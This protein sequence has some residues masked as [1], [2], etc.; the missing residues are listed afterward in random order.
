MYHSMMM[1]MKQESILSVCIYE[2][3]LCWT[4]K[5]ILTAP[6]ALRHCLKTESTQVHLTHCV[7]AG[8]C[9][10]CALSLTLSGYVA[11]VLREMHMESTKH[12][13]CVQSVRVQCGYFKSSYSE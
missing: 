10:V 4:K 13:S 3:L 8:T 9:A 2:F 7:T 6:F 5:N 12:F 1:M 11:L